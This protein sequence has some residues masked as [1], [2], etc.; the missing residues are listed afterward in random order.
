[1]CIFIFIFL[2]GGG[3]GVKVCQGISCFIKKYLIV[4]MQLVLEVR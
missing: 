1:M 3:A 4:A 2:L